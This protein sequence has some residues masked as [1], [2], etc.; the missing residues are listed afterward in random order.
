[1]PTKQQAWWNELTPEV[2]DCINHGLFKRKIF[3][4]S[5]AYEALNQFIR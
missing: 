4:L 2:Q 1:M 5:E 3:S